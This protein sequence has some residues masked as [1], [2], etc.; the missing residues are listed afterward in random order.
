MDTDMD[1]S[2]GMG[3]LHGH[4]HA[5]WTVDMHHE[6]GHAPWTWTYSMDIDMDMQHGY[7]HIVYGHVDAEWT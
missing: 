7:E 6:L 1:S 3:R 4:R 5:A 2:M